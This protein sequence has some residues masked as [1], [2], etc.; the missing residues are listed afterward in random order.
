MKKLCIL[1]A[2]V[3][4]CIFASIA[5]ASAYYASYSASSA[6]LSWGGAEALYGSINS[7]ESTQTTPHGGYTQ[8]TVKCAV[9]H[10]VHR[11]STTGTAPG[12]GADNKL[13]LGGSCVA[14]H[15]ASGGNA[16]S[17]LIEFGATSTGPHMSGASDCNAAGCHGSVHNSGTQS[18]YA[19]VRKYNLA[20]RSSVSALDDAIAAAIKSGN[21]P[22]DTDGNEVTTTQSTDGTTVKAIS[23][24]SL[25]Q[26]MKAY[27]TGYVCYAC[28][29]SSS[30]SVANADFASA[31]V[32]KGHLSIGTS[33]SKYIPTCEG[34]HDV[35]GVATNTTLFPHANRGVDVYVGRFNHQTQTNALSGT[36]RSTTDTDAT[37]Y[38]LWMTSAN[39]G[40]NENAEPVAGTIANSQSDW[41][42][43]GEATQT[44]AQKNIDKM[45][46]DGMCIKCHKSGTLR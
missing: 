42:L 36:I 28:H 11:A 2:L 5:P 29:G 20:N 16:S 15:A 40:D 4:M 22:K 18:Q 33:T 37:R 13:L 21:V 34:C 35:V 26:G 30:R 3:G 46:V 17:R 14:C 38:G 44:V 8:T 27:A 25:D 31:S 39:Y 19:I 6:Y 12:T 10:S 43:S 45:L 7:T 32:Y 23:E 1:I 41:Q 24:K 9:C